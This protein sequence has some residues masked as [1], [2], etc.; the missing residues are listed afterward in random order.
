MCSPLLFLLVYVVLIVMWFVC[1]IIFAILIWEETYISNFTSF[2]A[3]SVFM[4]TNVWILLL[5]FVWMLNKPWLIYGGK[6][7]SDVNSSLSYV[8]P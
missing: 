4:Y 1:K 2:P 8:D 7:S 6:C 5:F 3:L